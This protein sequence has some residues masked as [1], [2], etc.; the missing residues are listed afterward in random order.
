LQ[1]DEL[2]VRRLRVT[3]QLTTPPDSHSRS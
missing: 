1:I 2:V 3:Q